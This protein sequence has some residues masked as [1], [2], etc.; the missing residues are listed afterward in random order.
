MRGS[1]NMEEIL[2]EYG[3]AIVLTMMGIAVIQG[4]RMVLLIL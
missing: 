4:L 1:K 3:I 2:E